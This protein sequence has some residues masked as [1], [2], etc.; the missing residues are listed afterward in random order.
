MARI[1]GTREGE[2]TPALIIEASN[3][4]TEISDKLDEAMRFYP[5]L[6]HTIEEEE[7]K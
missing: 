4:Q 7:S 3:N 1:I 5:D 6:E 2:T